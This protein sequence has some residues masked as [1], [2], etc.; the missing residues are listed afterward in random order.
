MSVSFYGKHCSTHSQKAHTIS[1]QRARKNTNQEIIGINTVRASIQK[2]LACTAIPLCCTIGVVGMAHA[3]SYVSG[4]QNWIVQSTNAGH[5][6]ATVWEPSGTGD[7]TEP[8]RIQQNWIVQ[9]TNQA[10]DGYFVSGHLEKV[11]LPSSSASGSSSSSAASEDG[12]PVRVPIP[13]EITKC[14]HVVP[15]VLMVGVIHNESG[16]RPY[17]INDNTTGKQYYLKTYQAAVQEG[18]YLWGH[19]QNID[20]GIT[21]V[22]NIYHPQY[23]PSYLFHSCNG[24]NAGAHI[25]ATLWDQYQNATSNIIYNAYLTAEHY[26]GSDQQSRCYGERLLLSIGIN[27]GVHECGGTVSAR[28]VTPAILKLANSPS[29]QAESQPVSD[30][31]VLNINELNELHFANNQAL[32]NPE[33]PEP[34]V[35]S[36]ATNVPAAPSHSKHIGIKDLIILLILAII[37]IIFFVFTG[38]TGYL[39]A[40]AASTAA[41][42]A[43][44]A[45]TSA[46]AA[47]AKKAADIGRSLGGGG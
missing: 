16:G 9:S 27:P 34:V 30:T 38:G 2:L 12:L 47:T 8:R 23:R 6:S 39:A 15:P 3:E 26:N 21:Q 5:L 37:A 45:L 4:T 11:S 10:N 33:A 14:E 7:A 36:P 41:S 42:S 25:L 28:G 40:S 1:N 17:V 44:S 35:S 31:G 13:A 46:V 18:E 29:Y 19:N 32:Q 43:F 20:E 24:I 22:N